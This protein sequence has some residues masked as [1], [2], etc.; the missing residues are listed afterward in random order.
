VFPHAKGHSKEDMA[1]GYGERIWLGDEVFTEPPAIWAPRGFSGPHK[2]E[3]PSHS[4]SVS[5]TAININI[6]SF[7]S[8]RFQLA[9]TT[10][11]YTAV[12]CC[13]PLTL[14]IPRRLSLKITRRQRVLPLFGITDP[15]AFAM[16]DQCSHVLLM[17]VQVGWPSHRAPGVSCVSCNTE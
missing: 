17:I 7:S 11:A 2:I 6:S 8:N 14:Q 10:S 13:C 3:R 4:L 16:L 5:S 15:S 1:R 12:E 9:K